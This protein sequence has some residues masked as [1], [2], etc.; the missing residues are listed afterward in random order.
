MGREVL[1]LHALLRRGVA[2]R[3]IRAKAL[4]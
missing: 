4:R 3:S 2:L 1:S